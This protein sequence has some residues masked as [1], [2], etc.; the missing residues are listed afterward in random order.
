MID[1]STL[2]FS[3]L[4]GLIPAIIVDSETDKILMLGFMNE[5]AL[6][7]TIETNKVTFFSRTKNA[8]WTKG[9]TSG[10]FLFVKDIITD[11]DNDSII[12]YAT[13]QGPTCHTGN[14]SCFGLEKNNLKFLGYLNDLIYQRKK[15]LPEGSYT[16]EL[17]KSGSDRIIQK[18]GEEATEVIIAAKNK[19]RREIIYE[20]ADLLYHLIVMLQDNDINL[21]DVITELESRH[22]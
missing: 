1:I 17:F 22:K 13:P 7:K 14:Y 8:L 18:V 16:T 11:C 2:N 10:N 4:N 20:S 9:E 12:V 19:S 5:Q 6:K 3:K 15:N 21:S